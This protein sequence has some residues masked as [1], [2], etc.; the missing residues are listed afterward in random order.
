M[1]YTPPLLILKLS[2]VPLVQCDDT[3]YDENLFHIEHLKLQQGRIANVHTM[4][5]RMQGFGAGGVK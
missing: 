4:Q 2:C 5:G 3:F 1:R